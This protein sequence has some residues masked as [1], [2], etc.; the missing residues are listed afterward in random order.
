MA[1][2]LWLTSL[3]LHYPCEP[4]TAVLPGSRQPCLP[5]RIST[6]PRPSKSDACTQLDCSG[7][8]ALAVAQGPAGVFGF[9]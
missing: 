7:V 2:W 9:T 5:G 8:P 3:S 4:H 1:C 6:Q